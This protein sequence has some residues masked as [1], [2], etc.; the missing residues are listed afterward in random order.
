MADARQSSAGVKNLRAMFENSAPSTPDSRGRSVSGN[1]SNDSAERPLSKVRSSFVAVEPTASAKMTTNTSPSASIKDRQRRGSFSLSE[2][3]DAEAIEEIHRTI[4]EEEEARRKSKDVVEVV[5]ENAIETAPPT[6]VATPLLTAVGK[7]PPQLASEA[8]SKQNGKKKALQGSKLAPAQAT[9][10]L[11]AIEA[12]MEEPAPL[13]LKTGTASEPQQNGHKLPPIESRPDAL[14]PHV[15]SMPPLADGASEESAL[16][17]PA[18]SQDFITESEPESQETP[19]RH[20]TLAYRAGTRTPSTSTAPK[21]AS[22]TSS[23]QPNGTRNHQPS[24]A[25]STRSSLASNTTL[26]GTLDRGVGFVK[27]RPRSPTRPLK[28]PAHLIAPTASSASKVRGA[29][30]SPVPPQSPAAGAATRLNGGS[31]SGAASLRASFSGPRPSLGVG[32]PRTPVR[33]AWGPPPAKKAAAS[34]VAA[35]KPKEAP[36]RE[37]REPDRGFLERMMRPTASS[38]AKERGAGEHGKP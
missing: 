21:P 30:A 18:S 10:V 4:S 22:R 24:Q 23:V 28:L 19:S 38:A 1:S 37:P 31:S 36:R 15:P 14:K 9:N 11:P 2:E 8:A 27:P 17:Q 7:R 6:A 29:T 12:A 13:Q 34:A 20:N 3:T 26:P 32:A 33:N 16:Q 35:P 5:P 25:R